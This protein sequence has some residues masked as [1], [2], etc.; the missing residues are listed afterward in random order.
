MRKYQFR[1]ESAVIEQKLD[2]LHSLYRARLMQ[3]HPERTA[4]VDDEK[5][6]DDIAAERIAGKKL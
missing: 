2:S 4:W 6:R 3:V 5:E 1:S